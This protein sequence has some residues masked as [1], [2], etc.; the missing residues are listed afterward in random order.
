MNILK[1]TIFTILSFSTLC[2]Q[3]T[4]HFTVKIEGYTEGV[5]KLL[6]CYVDE[7]YLADSAKI[8]TQGQFSFTRADSYVEGMYYILTPDRD[9][10]SFFIANGEN[11]F[12]LKTKRGALTQAM[13]TEG[14]LENQLYFDNLKYQI[15]L[16]QKF[17]V[18][19]Q[20][21]QALS[22][23]SPQWN[24][25]QKEQQTML[26]NRDNLVADLVKQYPKAFFPKFKIAGQNP[27]LRV[28]YTSN[29]TM[30][31]TKTMANYRYDWWNDVD[32]SDE[33][34]IR[35]PVFFNKMKKYVTELT[36][37]IPD[38]IIAAADY[39]IDK[40]LN[41]KELFNVAANWTAYQY[42]PGL[43]KVMD[44]EAIYSHIILKYF[45]PDKTYWMKP[46]ELKSVRE[47]AQNMR[48]SLIGMVGQNVQAK[49]KNGVMRSIYDIKTPY[50]VVYIYTPD[51]EHCQ[52]ETPR[53]RKVYDTWKSRGLE[54]FSIVMNPKSRE[55]WQ[56]FAQKF[57][58]NWIDV[59]DPSVISRYHEKYHIDITP[60]L[61][62]L[63]KD[64]RII[65]KNLKPNQL[66]EVLEKELS[67]T[68]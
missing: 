24:E 66:P 35:T 45:T 61:Y 2:A 10:F 25:L 9:N 39:F 48:S 5:A 58:V 36:Y 16:E 22:P 38:S 6:G 3:K 44:G 68:K 4:T 47:S 50:K 1:I 65:A 40:T 55:E 12:T 46:E 33:R 19:A 52:E 31:S 54:I 18:N 27:K 21:L 34:L 41:T 32:F 53:L 37:Q 20:K 42:K 29:G 67:K 26:E 56:G 64:N 63:D 15:T 17:N 13:Q 51:C 14:T 49:D 30:D 62:L 8:D 7:T 43:S 60:E 23:N 28:S 11:N 59:S 57:G